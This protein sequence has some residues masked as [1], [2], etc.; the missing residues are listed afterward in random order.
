MLYTMIYNITFYSLAQC[1]VNKN[2]VLNKEVHAGECF[3]NVIE[4]GHWWLTP[5][6]IAT[7]EAEIGRI[8]WSPTWDK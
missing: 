2:W 4:S 5:V 6:I 7:W 8:S 3:M 1:L